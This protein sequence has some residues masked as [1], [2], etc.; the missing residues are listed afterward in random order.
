MKL[1]Q[2]LKNRNLLLYWFGCYNL[3]AGVICLALIP[4]DKQEILGIS[5]WIKPA[6]FFL[7]VGIMI[8]TMAWLLYYLDAKKSVRK[9][10]WLFV[11]TLFFENAGIA[12]QAIRGERSHFN[13]NSAFNSIVFST[14]GSLILLFTFGV[15]YVLILFFRQK[16]FSIS[17]SYYWGI[18][19]GLLFFIFFSFEGGVMVSLLSHTVGGADGGPGLP[20]VNWSTRYGD[21][22]I[23][24]FLGLHSLQVLPLIGYY[25]AA[26]KKQVIVYSFIYFA[27][28]I[29]IL[30]QAL[31]G[32]PLFF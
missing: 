2:T 16:Q 30:I 8:W 29:A 26:T 4:I 1:L 5:R 11:I 32:I 9:I 14:M 22:R 10:S 18:R 27:I 20:V 23:A 7:S 25:L 19:M 3:L 31:N 6:K 21:L 15:I 13:V 24:H 17:P 12:M 28:V